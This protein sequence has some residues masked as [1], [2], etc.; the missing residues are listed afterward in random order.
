MS[1]LHLSRF[2]ANYYK[3]KVVV[4]VD[5]YDAPIHDAFVN[6]YYNEVIVFM[7]S[8][9]GDGFKDN[10]HIERGVI[11]GILHPIQAGMDTA[12]NNARVHTV[13]SEKLADKFGFVQEEIDR[14]LCDYNLAA[15][16]DDF[17]FRYGDYHIGNFIVYNPSCVFT[18]IEAK[19]DL[20]FMELTQKSQFIETMKECV[21]RALKQIKDKKYAVELHSQGITD[22]AFFGIACHKKEIVLKQE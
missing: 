11:T 18:A 19:I 14:L 10:K 13:F 16:A 12:I 6:G 3:T 22:I 20:L 21:D 9:L 5:E 2:L 17:K 4:L 1:L 15:F 8:F 7:R